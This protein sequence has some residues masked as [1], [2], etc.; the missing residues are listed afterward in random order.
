MHFSRPTTS[1][2]AARIGLLALLVGLAP[3]LAQAQQ[4]MPAPPQQPDMDELRLAVVTAQLDLTQS[5][6]AEVKSALA[7]EQQRQQTLMQ[8]YGPRMQSAAADS[9]AAQS[10]RREM[11]TDMQEMKEQTASNLSGVLNQDQIESYRTLYAE[12]PEPGAEPDRVESSLERL[13]AQLGLTRQQR[14]DLRPVLTQQFDE[15]ESIRERMQAAGQDQAKRQK[16]M[17]DFKQMQQESQQ[18]MQAVL[19]ETQMQKMQKIQ[20][21]Q[22]QLQQAQQRMRRQRMQRMQQMQQQRGGQ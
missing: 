10:L 4:Q 17:A 20:Q 2:R 1:L 15:M 18:Q 5:Q 22:Q 16:V 21:A 7:D 3:G 6:R 12:L 14:A 13:D 9:G 8:E 11:R 19:N